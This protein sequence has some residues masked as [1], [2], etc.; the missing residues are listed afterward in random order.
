M[1]NAHPPSGRFIDCLSRL[2]AG[3]L[4]G[5]VFCAQAE[6]IRV[7]PDRAAVDL[8]QSFQVTFSTHQADAKEPDWTPLKKDFDVLATQKRFSATM[9]GAS[10]NKHTI[11]AVQLRPKRSGALLIPSLAFGPYNSPTK[12]IQVA[13]QLAQ[14][15]SPDFFIQAEAMPPSPYVQ[16]ETILIYRFFMAR[17]MR[18]NYQPPVADGVSLQPLGQGR[19]FRQQYQG[20]NYQVHELKFIFRPQR[21]GQIPINPI[22]LTFRYQQGNAY[23]QTSIQSPPINLSVRGVPKNYPGRYWLPASNLELSEQPSEQLWQA[24]KPFTRMITM[25]VQGLDPRQLPALSMP[26]IKAMKVYPGQPQRRKLSQSTHPTVSE[27]TQKVVYIPARGG[28]YVVPAVRV[29]WWNVTTD[30]LEYATL[31]EQKISVDEPDESLIAI[32]DY[33]AAQTELHPLLVQ[34]DHVWQSLWFWLTVL[35]ALLWLLTLALLFRGRGHANRQSA[36]RGA[37]RNRPH[38][39]RLSKHRKSLQAACQAHDGKAARQALL[40][41]TAALYPEKTIAGLN[42]VAQQCDG[43]LHLAIKDLERALYSKLGDWQGQLLWQAF[44]QQET[45]LIRAA[46]RRHNNKASGAKR[47][48]QLAPLHKLS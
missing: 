7:N 11:W 18:G 35:L 38:R 20:K 3:C 19:N 28:D 10:Q 15:A 34:T 14:A 46:Q 45:A 33:G 31:A 8:G 24:G 39:E 4:L 48:A 2:L 47:Q 6:V 36:D 26:T 23:R 25:K 21:S 30:R 12:P 27:Q 37:S 32:D 5:A 41:W 16:A 42:A 44:T 29:P 43:A 22:T 13:A 40:D 9:T 1:M 17:T